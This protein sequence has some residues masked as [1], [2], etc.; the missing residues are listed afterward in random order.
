MGFGRFV[1]LTAAALDVGA[2]AAR[3]ALLHHAAVAVGAKLQEFLTGGA[4][5]RPAVGD[6]RQPRCG[7][8]HDGDDFVGDDF[9]GRGLFNI[10]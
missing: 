10:V 3:G 5:R 8:V 4:A 6:E 7:A 1:P 9:V 2:I